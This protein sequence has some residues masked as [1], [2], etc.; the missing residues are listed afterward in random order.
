MR[1]HFPGRIG[2][3]ASCL[4]T[5]LLI[6]ASVTLAQRSAAVSQLAQTATADLEASRVEAAVRQAR[7]LALQAV[8]APSAPQALNA[9]A[10]TLSRGGMDAGTVAALRDLA[11]LQTRDAL[12]RTGL[13]E[14]TAATQAAGQA[15]LA[16]AVETGRLPVIRTV[17]ALLQSAA[18]DATPEQ[19]LQALRDLQASAAVMRAAENLLEAHQT[20]A[21]QAADM[22]ALGAL[23]AAQRADLTARLTPPDAARPAESP[24]DEDGA[25][26]QAATLAQL[27]ALSAL[28]ALIGLLVTGSAVWVWLSK[29]I[30]AAAARA[31]ALGA[32][33]ASAEERVATDLPGMARL[34]GAFDAL[35]DQVMN[36]IATATRAAEDQTADA[37]FL[38]QLARA[39]QKVTAGDL[40][41]RLDHDAMGDRHSAIAA[42]FNGA[43]G[44]LSDALGQIIAAAST[45]ADTAARQHDVSTGLTERTQHQMAT[46]EQTASA[47][48]ALTTTV[49]SAATRAGSVDKAVAEA[50]A[51]A[52]LNSETVKQAVRAMEAIEQG[53]RQITKVIGVIDDIAFQT[54]LLSLNA[55]VE[56]ARAGEA[57]KG[58][59]VVAAEVR[60][61]AHRSAEAA[62]EV[63]ALIDNSTRHVAEGNALVGKAGDALTAII[64]RV[65]AIA[66]MTTDIAKSMQAQSQGMAEINSGVVTLDDMTQTNLGRMQDCLTQS[67]ALTSEATRLH[68]RLTR[69]QLPKAGPVERARTLPPLDRLAAAI[70]ET[71]DRPSA[72]PPAPPPRPAE[73]KEAPR[74]QPAPRPAKVI[75]GPSDGDAIWQDF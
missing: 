34:S 67:D 39:L 74:D 42:A 15:L 20:E 75:G 7:E 4:I 46:L 17:S 57:G 14:A 71:N 16:V 49:Q 48:E 66:G 13:A 51:E 56:A 70:K 68:R 3:L 53:A 1:V 41:V 36:S 61:L 24:I 9:A 27:S 12:S 30:S 65:E 35:E 44:G 60:A 40:T 33:H 29:G 21:A 45:I 72:K 8:G 43:I 55:G 18:T 63:A 22:A 50:R 25:T 69:F 54:N 28:A 38:D 58:F 19:A 26:S 37:R 64:D 31:E 73:T 52:A 23:I 62:R 5:I 2:V 10:E 32:G 6:L 11:A 47:M 59:A